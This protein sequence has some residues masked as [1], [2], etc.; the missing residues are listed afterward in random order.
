MRLYNDLMMTEGTNNL[1][2][3]NSSQL[4]SD[5]QMGFPDMASSTLKPSQE[6]PPQT[7]SR[8]LP[9]VS[10]TSLKQVQ[11]SQRRDGFVLI[12]VRNMYGPDSLKHSQIEITNDMT[13]NMFFQEFRKQYRSLRGR[14]YWLHFDQFWF[15]HSSRFYKW[16]FNKVAWENHEMPKDACYM[17]I[18]KPPPEPYSLPVSRDEWEHRYHRN[19]SFANDD[20]L[21]RIPKRDTRFEIDTCTNPHHIWGLQVEYRVSAR[22]IL[23]W[24]I[25]FIFP[26]IIFFIVWVFRFSNDLQ[27]A[28]VPA[29]FLVAFTGIILSLV[30]VRFK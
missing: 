20:F 27:N 13:D 7:H 15:C 16:D 17:F 25:C 18:P 3:N 22:V 30:N 9:P 12:C 2:L 5:T 19:C 29:L 11:P 4:S 23:A 26:G 24:L 21:Y 14:F 10:S 1:Q 8:F 6:V 28:S